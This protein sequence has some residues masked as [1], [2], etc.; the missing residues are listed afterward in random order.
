MTGPPAGP[1]AG[2]CDRA[3]PGAFG[4]QLGPRF[5]YSG[6]FSFSCSL[7]LGKRGPFCLRPGLVAGLYRLVHC[8]VLALLFGARVVLTE[9]THPRGVSGDHLIVEKLKLSAGTLGT[10][11]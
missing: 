1:P 5:L 3:P 8:S 9:Q 2:G 6:S 10:R 11:Y 7:S 4:W